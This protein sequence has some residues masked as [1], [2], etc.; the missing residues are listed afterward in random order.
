MRVLIVSDTHRK[1][2]NFLQVIADEKPFDLVLHCG[3]TEGSEHLFESACNCAFQAVAGNNDFF[4]NLPQELEL[5]LEGY[6]VWMS[7]G[8]RY[9]VSMNTQ[10]IWEE[11]R[12]KEVQIVLF[13]HT[14]RPLVECRQGIW[15]VNPGSL[16]YPRQEG[17]RPS[18]IVGELS[19][20]REPAFVIHYL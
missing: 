17:R 13:G 20:D 16:S 18:Y 4:T 8:H 1:N 11:G 9:Y 2:D 7:H 15:L 5:T 19:P 10:R 12:A 14:H 6:R 3:D